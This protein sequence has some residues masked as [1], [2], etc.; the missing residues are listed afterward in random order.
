[1]TKQILTISISCDEKCP[2]ELPD[3]CFFCK[4]YSGGKT[5]VDVIEI[6]DDWRR[7]DELPE[8]DNDDEEKKE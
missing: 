6:L 5:T 8:A 7:A 4:K 2:A 1:M 3:T